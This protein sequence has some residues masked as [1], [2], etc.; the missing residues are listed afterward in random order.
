MEKDEAAK[1]LGRRGGLARAALLSPQRRS[2]I[3]RIASLK[4]WNKTKEDFN[5]KQK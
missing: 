4:R 5:K 3:A 2:E 1:L